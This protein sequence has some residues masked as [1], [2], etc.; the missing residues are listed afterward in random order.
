VQIDDEE[1]M[2]LAESATDYRVVINTLYQRKLSPLYCITDA[3]QLKEMDVL[4]GDSCVDKIYNLFD[5]KVRGVY[6]IRTLKFSDVTILYM[7][8]YHN[9]IT[10]WSQLIQR[11]TG[12]NS[13]DNSIGGYLKQLAEIIELYSN[14][15]YCGLVGNYAFKYQTDELYGYMEYIGLIYPVL[16]WYEATHGMVE[17]TEQLTHH[18]A[19]NQMR[20]EQSANWKLEVANEMDSI[21]MFYNGIPKINTKFNKL[22]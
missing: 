19:F 18:N 8:M 6:D 3:S 13:Y 11:R 17:I 2:Q 14:V 4:Q 16:K 21:M 1:C 15:M 9:Y 10:I 20:Q 22:M 12:N 7:V 5:M